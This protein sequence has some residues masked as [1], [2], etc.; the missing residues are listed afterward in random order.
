M[1]LDTVS[2]KFALPL[3][4]LPHEAVVTLSL[5]IK[6]GGFGLAKVAAVAVPAY[7][8]ALSAAS[9][10]ITQLLPGDMAALLLFDQKRQAPFAREVE[11]CLTSLI[12]AGLMH[13]L[14]SPIPSTIEDFWKPGGG[15]VNLPRRQQGI[16][17]LLAVRQFDTWFASLPL[18]TKQRLQSASAPNAGSWLTA[19]PTSPELTMVDED[20]LIAVKHRLGLH[21]MEG[22]PSA[23]P[24]CP[25]TPNISTL[26]P[27]AKPRMRG[28]T[29]LSDCS[30][31]SSIKLEQRFAWNPG[32]TPRSVCVL[33]WKSFFPT[34]T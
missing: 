14:D 13:G 29:P 19:F 20:F 11:V 7:F 8:C 34:S 12:D 16:C 25:M 33:T 27:S 17:Q 26:A 28:T 9:E 5:P 31:R 24:R 22:L 21:P 15:V 23:A 18:K 32:T 1:V 30:L 3:L 4:P 6:A 2:R 10:A